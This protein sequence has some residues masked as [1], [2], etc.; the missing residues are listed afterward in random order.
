[1]RIKSKLKKRWITV[2]QKDI[3]YWIGQYL[4]AG[5]VI[6]AWDT[7]YGSPNR[8]GRIGDMKEQKDGGGFIPF[9]ARWD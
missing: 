2:P 5:M 8:L 6:H 4:M 7:K 9:E 1:M 3:Y